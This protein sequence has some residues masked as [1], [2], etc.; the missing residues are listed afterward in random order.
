MCVGGGE[1]KVGIGGVEDGGIIVADEIGGLIV[2]VEDIDVLIL[3]RV[4]KAVFFGVAMVLSKGVCVAG[5]GGVISKE[6]IVADGDAGIKSPQIRVAITSL[7]LRGVLVVAW[8][9]S[10]VL[11]APILLRSGMNL[12]IRRNKIMIIA[13]NMTVTTQGALFDFIVHP[14]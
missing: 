11:E 2:I 6:P 13:K 9:G 8:V 1:K 7:R 10:G 5:R 3:V 12:F 14:R 4:G